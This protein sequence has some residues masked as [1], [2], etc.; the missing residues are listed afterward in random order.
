MNSLAKRWT[1]FLPLLGLLL[2]ETPVHSAKPVVVEAKFKVRLERNV[3][4]PMRDGKTL[5]ADLIRPDAEGKFPALI[6]YIPYRKDDLTH[7]GYDAHW[8]LAERGFVGVRVDVR[9]TG[10]SEERM[11]SHD[12]PPSSTVN[13]HELGA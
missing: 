8:Y 2:M 7:G 12:L 3:R 6:E 11:A 13:R 10:T 1:F 9:G 5:S 4:I